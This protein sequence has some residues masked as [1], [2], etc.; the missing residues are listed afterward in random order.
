MSLDKCCFCKSEIK[1]NRCL[2]CKAKFLEFDLN[3]EYIS[4]VVLYNVEFIANKLKINKEI[5]K[6][7]LENEGDITNLLDGIK[8]IEIKEDEEGVIAISSKLKIKK[9]IIKKDLFF[10]ILNYCVSNKLRKLEISEYYETEIYY[11]NEKLLDDIFLIKNNLE[12]N[13]L[14]FDYEVNMILNEY[15][16]LSILTDDDLDEIFGRAC[17]VLNYLEN[18]NGHYYEQIEFKVSLTE[19]LNKNLTLIEDF[20]K[21]KYKEYLKNLE[22]LKEEN[23]K[24]FP[25]EILKEK[26]E[27]F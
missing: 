2:K 26:I 22:K 21:L 12:E 15:Y 10:N 17:E 4:D 7:Y 1:N 3:C 24:Y 13:I 8:I 14:L 11:E 6:I 23:K 25:E 20:I 5:L 18:I 9:E 19:D 16:N 27:K